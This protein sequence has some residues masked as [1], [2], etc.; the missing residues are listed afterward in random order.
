MTSAPGGSPHA[1]ACVDLAALVARVAGIAPERIDARLPL[2]CL[3]LDSLAALE[4]IAALEDAL[5]RGI[6]ESLSSAHTTL[7]DLAAALA[8][9]G[10]TGAAG[11]PDERA[12]I[13]SDSRLADDIAVPAFATPGTRPTVLL[14]GATGFLGPYLLRELLRADADVV[15]CLVRGA[16]GAAGTRLRAALERCGMGALAASPRVQTVAADI[17]LPRFGLDAGGWRAL[18][19]T[20]DTVY[21]AAAEVNWILPYVS[22]RDANVMGTRELL[23]FACEARPKAFHFISSLSV[24]YASGMHLAGEAVCE[25]TDMARWVGALPLGYAR[26]KCVA[27]S[28]VRSVS[29]RG[30]SARIYRPGLIAGDSITGRSNLADIM[31]ALVKGCIETGAAPDLDWVFDAPAVDDVARAVVGLSAPPGT[32]LDTLHLSHDRPRSWRE[33]VLWMNLR[34]YDCP[35]LPYDD[36]RARIERDTRRP[37][38]PLRALRSFFL[39]RGSDGVT[40]AERFEVRRRVAIDSRATIERAAAAGLAAAPLDAALLGRYFD[41]YER[42]GFLP[43]PAG[44]P[45]ARGVA[46]RP[47]WWEQPRALEAALRRGLRDDSLRVTAVEPRRSGSAHSI[48]GELTAWRSG[49]RAGLHRIRATLKRSARCETLDLVVKAKARDEDAMDVAEALARTCGAELADAVAAN[50]TRL[51]LAASH[52]REI[53]I[54]E[55]PDDRL[56]LHR[57]RCYGTWHDHPVDGWGLLLESLEGLHLLDSADDPSGWTLAHIDAVVAGLAEIHAAYLGRAGQL[58]RE[59]WIGHVATLASVVAMTPLWTALAR[60]A[61]PRFQAWAG[62]AAVDRHRRLAE[63]PADWWPGICGTPATLIHHDFNPRNLGL[64]CNGDGAYRLCAYDWEL[65]T[66]GAPQRD[67]AEFLCF[68][69]MPD[70][71]DTL[72]AT[73]IERHRCLL[74]RASGVTLAAD[75]WRAGMRAAMADLLTNRL[76]FYAMIDRVRPQ[77]FLPRV[78][79]TWTRLDRYLGGR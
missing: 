67:L 62:A 42:R 60:D 65:A 70:A 8:P 45:P 37:G 79:R 41:D 1:P 46:G 16:P 50:R 9:Q 17:T 72:I 6:P 71:D 27:E 14:T 77:A 20:V 38:H 63:A 74:G 31:A 39:A 26:S 12:L 47:A 19:E 51:G 30:L 28:L 25:S 55:L 52:R 7:N 54:Y 5:G 33:C 69:L 78:V 24:C 43:P 15:Y 36:W 10:A 2:G 29:S 61:A 3:G 56:A 32:G 59:P 18:A 40:A 68:V 11:G 44:A 66:I 48:I 21:H 57:P 76:A 53:A 34:G 4:L 75:A 64:R 23:R 58:R 73:L 35:L 22:L 13:E 49:T